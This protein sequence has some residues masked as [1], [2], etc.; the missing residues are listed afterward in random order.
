VR[1]V[2]ADDHPI[3]LTGLAVLLQP[4]PEIG[5]VAAV[6]DGATAIEV[7][8]AHEP[9][10][11]VLDINMPALTGLDVLTALEEDGWDDTKQDVDSWIELATTPQPFGGRRWWFVCPRTGTRVAKLHLPPGAPTFASRSRKLPC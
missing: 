6:P 9:E 7:I 5:I 10:I 3:V 11:A 2:L 1:I 8:G 4:E